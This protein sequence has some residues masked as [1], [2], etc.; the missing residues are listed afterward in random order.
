M[1]HSKK[2]A[3]QTIFV[4]GNPDI[5]EDAASIAMIPELEKEFPDVSFLAADPNELDI[6]QEKEM[7]IIDIV[8][9][10]QK[11]R[12]VEIEELEK[13]GKQATAHDFDASAYLLLV[14]KLCPD[15]AIRI[16]GLPPKAKKCDRETA[17]MLL[18][19][20]FEKNRKT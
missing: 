13:T 15:I 7:I 18:Q 3:T 19:K 17:K 14:K 1:P 6:P 11:T 5:P 12:W 16:L 9:G 8:Y 2:K 10:L 4:F 20:H